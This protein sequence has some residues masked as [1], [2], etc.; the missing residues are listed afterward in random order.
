MRSEFFILSVP[1][2]DCIGDKKWFVSVLC[3]AQYRLQYA[4]MGLHASNH[5]LA[6]AEALECLHDGSIIGT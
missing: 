6:F 5:D 3:Q 2:S 4:Y 1:R